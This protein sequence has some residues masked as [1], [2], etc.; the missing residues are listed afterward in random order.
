[1]TD[2][3]RIRDKGRAAGLAL[4]TA[5]GVA[6]AAALSA[7]AF[8]TRSAFGALHSGAPLPVTMLALLAA[9]GIASAL[10]HLAARVA[11]ER[12]GQH[13]IADLRHTLYRHIAGMSVETLASRRV[14]ALSMRFV[15]DLSAARLW[16]S[17]G[18]TRG[19]ASIAVLPGAVVAMWLVSPA[20]A[21]AALIPLAIT[22]VVA[23]GIASALQDRHR[24]LRRRRAAIAGDMM[25]R[26]AIAPQLDLAG[27]TGQELARLDDNGRA[28]TGDAASR[29]LRAGLL[30]ALPAIG[31][32]LSGVAVL[33]TAMRH[34]L[35][36]AEVAAMLAALSILMMPLGDLAGVWDRFCAWRIARERCRALLALP[37]TTRAPQ[38]SGAVRLSIEGL[39]DVPA[40]STAI[41]SGRSASIALRSVAA[42]GGDRIVD[43]GLPVG[44][45][46]QIAYVTDRAVILRGS[47]RLALTIGVSPRPDPRTIRKVARG[48]GLTPLLER[49][50]STRHRIAE[51]G[52]DLSPIERLGVEMTRAALMRPDLVVIDHPLIAQNDP[53]LAR[54][55]DMTGATLIVGHETDGPLCLTPA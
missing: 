37:S 11:G 45:L 5:L 21:P 30:R 22:G 9:G 1:M 54:L 14:G 51:G 49:L 32:A 35:P 53:R 7:V 19:I 34:A 18:V 23:V 2:L 20:L 46:P 25:E 3:P 38:R 17:T 41:L 42:Q 48:F 55:A 40:G 50:G 12:M 33:A 36:A 47:L 29:A 27:R 43:Y 24:G 52:H 10:L 8:A 4:V 6:Q 44:Q 15:G 39:G 28:L 31:A 13:Y 16:V 26:I